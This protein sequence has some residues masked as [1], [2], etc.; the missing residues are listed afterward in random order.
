MSE[1][2][3]ELRLATESEKKIVGPNDLLIATIAAANNGTLVTRNTTEF[4]VIPHLKLA[5]W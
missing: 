2:Y 4:S 1:T 5:E 3:A